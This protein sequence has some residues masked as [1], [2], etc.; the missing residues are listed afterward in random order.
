MNQEI[1]KNSNLFAQCSSA[2]LLQDTTVMQTKNN[3]EIIQCIFSWFYLSI[4]SN[5]D[6]EKM[7]VW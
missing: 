1:G 6:T 2:K 5:T 7:G 4:L 3:E